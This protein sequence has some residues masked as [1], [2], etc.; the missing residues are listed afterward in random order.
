MALVKFIRASRFTFS[1]LRYPTLSVVAVPPNVPQPSVM[2]GTSPGDRAAAALGRR[3]ADEDAAGRHGPGEPID[4][5]LV[6]GVDDGGVPGALVQKQVSGTTRSPPS[7]HR[8][9]RG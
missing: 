9:R 2:D 8:W 3:D 5:L 4:E 1:R 6:V 7:R